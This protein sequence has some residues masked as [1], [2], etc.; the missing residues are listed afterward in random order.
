[1]QKEAALFV[2]IDISNSRTIFSAMSEG[3]AILNDFADMLNTAYKDILI[4]PFSIKDGDAIV[5]GVRD[6]TALLH[7]YS[8]CLTHY[9]SEDFK[10]SF[11]HLPAV[12]NETLNFYFGAGIGY[13]DTQSDNINI[14]NGTSI[15]NAIEASNIAKTITKSQTKQKKSAVS[16]NE[17]YFFSK[18]P[19]KFYCLAD[20]QS[21][22]NVVNALFFLAFEQLIR[23]D[24]QQHLF[25]V[26]DEHPEYSNIEIGMEMGYNTLSKADI[27]SRI[28]VLMANSDYYL[29]T[30]VRQD[31]I[32]FLVDLQKI[33]KGAPN[34]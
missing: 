17:N 32:H 33:M 24:K 15:I 7:I 9:Y 26:K 2:Y 21:F 27:S 16:N 12:Q 3:T 6:L 22:G 14:V 30:K 10:T 23:S 28:S 19:F 31:I 34:D 4:T 18:Q 5:G 25:R 8:N 29:Y 1:M 13:I 20:S 11:K